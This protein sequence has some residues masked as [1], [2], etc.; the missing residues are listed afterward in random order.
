M[1]QIKPGETPFSE[2]YEILGFQTQ[3]ELDFRKA[4]LFPSGNTEQETSTTSIFLASLAAVKEYR[5]EL[6]LGIG[7]NKIRN[8][9][10]NV[11]AYTEIKKENKNHECRPDGLLI[12]TSGKNNPLI[13][14]AALVE[15]KVGN[16]EVGQKQVDD[17][18]EFGKE[19]GVD[20]LITI[21]NQLVTTPNDSPYKTKKKKF[22]LYHWSWTF[23]KVAARRLVRAGVIEDPDHEYILTELRR[24]FDAHSKVSNFT[25]MGGK[26]WK[27]ATQKCRDTNH[28]TKLPAWCT[29]QLVESFKQEEKDIALQLTDLN[30]DGHTVK[31]EIGKSDREEQLHKML[32]EQRRITSTY[33]IDNDKA[34]SFNLTIDFKTWVVE[35][36]T[37][38]VIDKG[39]AQAQTT[40]LLG[41]F[42]DAGASSSILINGFYPRRKRHA[43]PNL[44]EIT[45]QQLID[46]KNDRA[47]N[48]YSTVNK[49][50]G[51]E[52]KCFETKTKD[53]LGAEFSA[54][55]K[56]VER[57]E[58][59]A[60]RFLEHVMI[61][62]R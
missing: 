62:I 2:L 29:N 58:D 11:H 8:K 50:L 41:L 42:D 44:D 9:N 34:W 30:K 17:Y 13:E 36:S 28:E 1:L 33:S 45:L 10:I 22:D 43:H 53:H 32:A 21:S 23:L 15:S 26:D 59:I 40:A 54:S 47:V 46:E 14:W 4:R 25:N 5:E 7:V 18:V 55:K 38:I 19:A 48:T 37:E 49:D 27:E 12:V 20:N 60:Q 39:K 35:C 31:L 52:F 16:S 61:N 51:D 6:L 57:I 56:F 3:E 24:Y